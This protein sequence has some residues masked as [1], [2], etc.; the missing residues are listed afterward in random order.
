VNLT[1][2]RDNLKQC[3][4]HSTVRFS[5]KKCPS[6]QN[7]GEKNMFFWNGK[8]CL[9]RKLWGTGPLHMVIWPWL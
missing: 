4:T 6:F 7:F 9:G 1:V 5:W 3:R 2:V 8:A